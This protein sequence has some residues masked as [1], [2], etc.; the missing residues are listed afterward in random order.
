MSAWLSTRCTHSLSSYEA[1]SISPG[2]SLISQVTRVE[3]TPPTEP[4]S[5]RLQD[6]IVAVIV[7][8][9]DPLPQPLKPSTSDASSPQIYSRNQHSAVL[10]LNYYIRLDI[11]F[12]HDIMPRMSL[13]F[14]R[15]LER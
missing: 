5:H 2:W 1:Q 10:F 4:A 14:I 12:W 11:E 15:V 7:N 6:Q 9:Y 3:S 8:A 13:N